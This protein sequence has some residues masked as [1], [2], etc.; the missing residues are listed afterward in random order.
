MDKSY[1][2]KH[3]E[4]LYKLA[5]GLTPYW[6]YCLSEMASSLTELEGTFC[7]TD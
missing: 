4:E 3:F 2:R 1:F 5:H 7:S 6:D